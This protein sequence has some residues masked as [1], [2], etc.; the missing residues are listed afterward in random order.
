MKR[1]MAFVIFFTLAI[2]A[3]SPSQEQIQAT[4]QVPIEETQNAIPT[5]TD[6][7]VPTNTPKPTSTPEPSPTPIVLPDTLYQTFSGIS[8][9]HRDSFEYVLQNQMPIGWDVTEKYSMW[10]TSENQ[11]I[12]KPMGDGSPWSRTFFAYLGENILP[13][14]GVFFTFKYTLGSS[15]EFTLGLDNVNPNEILGER[16][17]N[18]H[19]VAMNITNGGFGVHGIQ[20][21]NQ[22]EGTFKGNLSPQQNTW[23]NIAIAFDQN[24]KFIIKIWDP[25]NPQ[26]QLT[27]LREWPDFPSEYYFISYTSSKW[28]WS[29]DDFTVFKFDEIIQQ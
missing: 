16:W 29:M 9:I 11:L 10:V 24:Q 20:R 22:I 17:D 13:N 4:V 8:V 15:E 25:N 3:C 7:S 28:S 21:N 19:S 5:A 14:S 18:F 2:N 27:Y 26:V 6:T 1:S 23:Y 12:I